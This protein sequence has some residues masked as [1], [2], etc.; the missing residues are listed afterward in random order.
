MVRDLDFFLQ[1][2]KKTYEQFYGPLDRQIIL[3]LLPSYL[4]QGHSSLI[5]MVNYFL[6]HA[7]KRSRYVDIKTANLRHLLNDDTK[8][9]LIGVS[10][11]LLDLAAKNS[12]AK[13]Y[14]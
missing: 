9:M 13:T 6:N 12:E 2:A 7:E 11:A 5:E 3:A 14:Q 1:M 10:Y 8:K 4:E